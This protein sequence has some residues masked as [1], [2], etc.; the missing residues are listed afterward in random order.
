MG[1]PAGQIVAELQLQRTVG[2]QD[3]RIV[4]PEALNERPGRRLAIP[5]HQTHELHPW[6]AVCRDTWASPGASLRHGAHHDAQTF[7][8]TTSP[9]YSD[10]AN[11]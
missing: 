9:R 2:V 11:C 5:R 4:Q 3:L 6:S 1:S 7:S 10:K 8:T